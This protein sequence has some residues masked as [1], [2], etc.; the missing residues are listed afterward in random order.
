MRTSRK[1]RKSLCGEW[2]LIE[3]TRTGDTAW[4]KVMDLGPYGKISP[5]G[6][7]FNGAVDRRE[8]KEQGRP[9]RK[10]RYRSI[11]D[12]SRSVSKQLNSKGMVKVKV[13]W[14]RNNRFAPLLDSLLIK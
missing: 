3:N 1:S 5:E 9:P 6:E 7:W 4:C 14:W 8:A 10:G 11:I 2:V 13:R 12:M